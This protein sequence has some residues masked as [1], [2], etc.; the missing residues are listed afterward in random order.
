MRLLMHRFP[1][2]LSITPVWSFF[3]PIPGT[4]DYHLMFRAILKNKEITDWRE[5]PS[6]QE[7]RRVY[8]FFWNPQKKLQKS[9]NDLVQELL[10][11]SQAANYESQIHLSIPYLHILNYVSSFPFDT[12]TEKIQFMILSSSRMSEHKVVFVSSNHRL[13]ES[14]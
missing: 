1:W 3:A 12:K 6:L 8:T 7:K 2:L 13:P 14:T 11:F 5:A 4:H 10:M 9:L